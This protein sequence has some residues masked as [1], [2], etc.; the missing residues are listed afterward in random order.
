MGWPKHINGR[1]L[2]NEIVRDK[3]EGANL[4]E[5]RRRFTESAAKGEE[6]RA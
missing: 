3:E 5:R 4:E 2:K 6:E 1:A